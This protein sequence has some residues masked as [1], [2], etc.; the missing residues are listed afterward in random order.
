MDDSLKVIVFIVCAVSVTLSLMLKSRYVR[1]IRRRL[2]E[3]LTHKQ[4]RALER[5]IMLEHSERVQDMNVWERMAAHLINGPQYDARR[6]LSPGALPAA[7]TV[8]RR[9]VPAADIVSVTAMLISVHTWNTGFVL[10]SFTASGAVIALY[11]IYRIIEWIQARRV[12]PRTI[13]K[14]R[15][16]FFPWNGR[17]HKTNRKY[18][19]RERSIM[20]RAYLLRFPPELFI[21]V[22]LLAL[23]TKL[24]TVIAGV[25]ILANGAIF[26]WH[27][28]KR[29]EIFYCAMQS[30]S[31]RAMTP[32][33]HSR[34]EMKYA[35]KQGRW[36]GIILMGMG[37]VTIA[38]S[39]FA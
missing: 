8:I 39:I 19:S 12:L 14:E 25:L 27:C 35:E 37:A 20:L 6:H 13:E 31:H 34:S 2:D 10:I 15:V 9:I 30:F 17:S 36:L 33:H 16:P 22:V 28:T 7:L 18:N 1:D 4:A 3:P 32:M 26:H 24:T 11:V 21:A 38:L 29:S 5:V 23:R